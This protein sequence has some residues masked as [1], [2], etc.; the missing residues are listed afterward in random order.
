MTNRREEFLREFQELLTRHRVEIELEE[1]GGTYQTD[2]RIIATFEYEEGNTPENI[3]FG[4][5]IDGEHP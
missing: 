5:Y 4:S 2:H 1:C 3:E